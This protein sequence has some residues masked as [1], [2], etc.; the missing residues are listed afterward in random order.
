MP[1]LR[2]LQRGI[3]KESLR[4]NAEGSIAQSPHPSILGSALTH[5]HITT[6]FSEALLEFITPVCNTVEE[7]TT[8]LNE[9]H[10]T[11]YAALED[12][13]LWTSSMPCVLPI[14]SSIPI[15][16][17][18][19]SNIATMKQVYRLGLGHRY[20]R[21]MQTI[22]GIHYNFSFSEEF[23]E[24]YRQE[25]GSKAELKDF[26][27]EQYFHLIRNFRRYSW[28]LV[29]LFGASPAVCKTFLGH[30]NHG[31]D[32]IG[33]G[34]L[35]S[36]YGTS[37]RMGDLGYQSQ[38]QESLYVCYNKLEEYRNTL[39]S[40]LN[41][42]YPDYEAIGTHRDGERIQ[43]NTSLLQIENEFYSTIRPKRN[44]FN[45]ETPLGALLDRGIE[46]IEVRCLDLNPF[47]PVAINAQQM[48]FLDTFL[49]FCLL[50]DSP[51]ADDQ[52]YTDIMENQRRIVYRG[53]DPA[54]TLLQKGQEKPVEQLASEL[55]GKLQKVAEL[56]DDHQQTDVHS[57][58][59]RELQ[60]YLQHPE[61]T[62]SARLLEEMSVS[63]QSYFQ[64]AM[65]HAQEHRDYF[66]DT[67]LAPEI[68][69]QFKAAAAL[70]LEKQQ[71]IEASDT[72]SFDDFLKNY[73]QQYD[74]LLT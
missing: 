18:G 65:R 31:L 36:K 42:P 9:I 1:S 48:H 24:L 47:L 74:N 55:F 2:A 66:L 61:L 35:Y 27:T 63:G 32:T 16:Q 20:G 39:A 50:Q 30:D 53:R 17:Y 37:L 62:P 23:W 41:M 44:T 45:N 67:P 13:L 22:A 7:V 70:S 40:A 8:W 26:K 57:A 56:L 5:P 46:Y 10:S 73:Y 34:T 69:D 71:Q 33:T 3:E 28:L 51:E 64:V 11:A 72:L 52:E 25:L 59:H 60:P 29:Y 54:L 19:S 4:V 12:E 49:V 58:A 43:L 38:A 68:A 15:A 21:A 6:D 14:D